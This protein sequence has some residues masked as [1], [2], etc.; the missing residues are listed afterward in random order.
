M[1][2][3]SQYSGE[4]DD[5]GEYNDDCICDEDYEYEDDYH[6]CSCDCS[7]LNET[8]NGEEC[9]ECSLSI[10]KSFGREVE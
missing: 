3:L 4:C 2:E 1:S 8:A 9:N 7:C 10:H 5:C 6:I